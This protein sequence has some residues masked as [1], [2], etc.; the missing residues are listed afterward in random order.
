[1]NSQEDWENIIN[2]KGKLYLC[3][4]ITDDLLFNNSEEIQETVI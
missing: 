1:M 4:L 2:D 3:L